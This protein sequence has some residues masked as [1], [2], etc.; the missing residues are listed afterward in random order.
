MSEEA[1]KFALAK[2]QQQSEN[3][4]RAIDSFNTA[5]DAFTTCQVCGNVVSVAR[6]SGAW[7]VLE[8]ECGA[9]ST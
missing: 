5:D 7:Q 3:A 6:V 9:T 8:H 4:E 2:R 1:Q